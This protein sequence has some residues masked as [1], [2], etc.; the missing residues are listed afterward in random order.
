M[1]TPQR[2]RSLGIAL[3]FIIVSAIGLLAAFVLTVEKLQQL[4]FPDS[5]PSCDFGLVVQCG[6][7][8]ASWQGSLF[9]FPNPT[10]GLI[11]WPVV[12]ATGV[13]ILAGAHF[14]TWYWR[15]FNVVA[16]LALVFVIWLISESI[17]TLGT[18]CPWCMVTWAV[19]IPL[20]WVTTFWNLKNGVWGSSDR[21]RVIGARL[22]GWTPTFIFLSF[23]TIALLAQFRLDVLSYL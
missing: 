14:A 1:D 16:G 5:K 7:N 3:F 17:F 6:K 15:A 2:S 11:A 23:L 8:L 22:L 12:M 18:L 20:L 9:G 19:V 10:L 21:A 13:A 4:Q